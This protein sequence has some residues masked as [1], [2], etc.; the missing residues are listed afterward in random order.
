MAEH[1]SLDISYFT[2]VYRTFKEVAEIA[3]SLI[4]SCLYCLYKFSCLRVWRI[5][6]HIYRA[7]GYGSRNSL[8]ALCNNKDLSRKIGYWNDFLADSLNL[9]SSARK[10]KRN[11]RAKLFGS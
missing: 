2:K 5:F 6:E 1:S 9:G 3:V 7:V 10:K 4:G 8:R 11:V